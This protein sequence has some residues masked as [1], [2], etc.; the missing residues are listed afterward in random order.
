MRR[1]GHDE[2]GAA[3]YRH[4]RLQGI[5]FEELSALLRDDVSDPTLNGVRI[6]S[7]VLSVDYRNARVHFAAPQVSDAAV[8]RAG[9]ERGLA[10]A[11][12]FLRARLA[13]GLDLKRIPEL[14]FVFD[15]AVPPQAEEESREG[16]SPCSE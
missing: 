10:R 6:T 2:Q 12:P 1:D 16:R 11:T 15:G 4:A 14:R 8:D 9:L 7:V 13:E 5:L 3:G